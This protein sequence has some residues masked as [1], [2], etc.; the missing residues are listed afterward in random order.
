MYCF[1]DDSND[2]AMAKIAKGMEKKVERV[3]LKYGK[4]GDKSLP[5]I[6]V[7]PY[8]NKVWL[9]G[10]NFYVVEEILHDLHVTTRQN[11]RDCDPPFVMAY[12]P[13]D[14]RRIIFR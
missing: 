2:K 3:V 14:K 5:E 6:S 11:H 13:D 9:T 7:D 4:A 8:E 10:G 1:Y 12:L